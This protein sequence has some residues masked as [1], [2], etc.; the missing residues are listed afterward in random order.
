MVNLIGSNNTLNAGGAGSNW[1][2]TFNSLGSNNQVSSGG[3]GGNFTAGFNVLG[4]TNT[5]SAGP[6]PLALA[7]TIF[8]NGATVT[9]TGPGIAINNFR[10]GGAQA[11]AGTSSKA[12]SSK[13]GGTGKKSGKTSG[14][15]G[16][17]RA[18]R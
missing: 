8:N 17:K 18:G 16:S 6:G 15:G 4:G 1:N 13:A 7:G 3:A 10:I 9:K 12:P 11:T 14:T 5:V 2:L